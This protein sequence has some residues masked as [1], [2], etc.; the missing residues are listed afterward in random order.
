MAKPLNI[1]F[2][3]S[4]V[5]PFAKES[6][7]A[8]VS[9]A[10]PIALRHMGHDVRL[11]LPKYGTI[12]ERRNRIYEINRL[13]DIPIELGDKIEFTTVK[14]TSVVSPGTKVQAYVTSHIGYFEEKTGVYHDPETWIEYQDNAERFIFFNKSVVETCNLLGWYP[15]IIH[16]NDW[17]T[18]L[19]PAL[20]RTSGNEKFKNT[21]TVFTIH[22]FYR[23]GVYGLHEFAKTGLDKSVLPNFKHKNQL[24]L[25]KGAIQYS[26]Y[27]TTVSPT[28]AQEILMD[29]KYSNGLNEVLKERIDKFK[30]ILN[31]I[32]SVGWNPARD[33]LIIEKFKKDYETFKTSNKIALCKIFGLEY[34]QDVPL[35]A[36]IPRIGYQKGVGLIIEASDEIFS[37]DI[38]FIL[39]GQGDA[40]LKEKLTEISNKY[41]DKVKLRYEFNEDLSHQVEAGCNFF[42]MPSQYEPCGLN[43]MYSIV[44]GAIPI[45][46]ATG[47]MKDIAIDVRNELEG[48]AIVFENYNSKELAVA[49]NRA[50]ELYSNNELFKTIAER[51]MKANYSWTASALEYES[52]YKSIIKELS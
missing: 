52:I 49:F 4:E 8:D 50:V 11:M 34:K 46:R 28:Y 23:Q 14:S 10:L 13:R 30:G 33:S 5:F 31:G 48:N 18:A 47:G 25:M 29:K 36:M 2:V 15:D 35:F 45:V 22:N 7:I 9:Y 24:N 40:D 12:S 26:N 19:L 41:P 43:L 1:L 17:Q 32:D 51:G 38:Q 21:G 39:L 42:L 16:C 20:I 44:Y 37:K 27:I 3:S 6:G